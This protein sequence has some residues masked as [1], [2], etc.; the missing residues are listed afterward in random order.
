MGNQDF[1]SKVF[2]AIVILYIAKV[3]F[4]FVY[5]DNAVGDLALATGLFFILAMIVTWQNSGSGAIGSNSSGG[6]VLIEESLFT[7]LHKKYREL[8]QKYENEKEYKKSAEV[9]LKLLKSPYEAAEVYER[10]S[11]YNE[12][13]ILHHR[14][15]NNK[16]K[17]A[18]CYEKGKSYQSAIKLYTELNQHER[19]GDVYTKIN[20]PEDAKKHYNI[21]VEDHRNQYQFVQGALVLKDKLKNLK[22]A[23]A[24]LFEGWQSHHDPKNCLNQYFANIEDPT[25]LK[26]EIQNIYKN[27]CPQNQQLLFLDLL[28]TERLKHEILE[29]PTRDIAYQIIS[30]AVSHNRKAL[31]QLAYFKPYDELVQKDVVRYKTKKR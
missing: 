18:D 9:Y 7:K 20:K 30:N 26:E 12:A 27:Y 31:D 4:I 6:D 21:V 10:G 22:A 15:L 16:P 25:V 19:L 5:S 2:R 1:S 17:A 14:K 29:K 13:A 23:Q 3:A 11:F 28:K 24:M 8:A